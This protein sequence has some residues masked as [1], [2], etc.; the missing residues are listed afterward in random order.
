MLCV[1]ISVC[2]PQL[3]SCRNSRPQLQSHSNIARPEGSYGLDVHRDFIKT[4]PL[5]KGTGDMG[6]IVH[7]QEP[8]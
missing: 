6:S 2:D 3:C 5:A 4:L 7:H 1:F 8:T